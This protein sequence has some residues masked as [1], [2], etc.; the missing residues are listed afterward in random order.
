[1]LRRRKDKQPP[2][3]KA[4]AVAWREFDREQEREAFRGLGPGFGRIPSFGRRRSKS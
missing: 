4:R 3:E 1:M 2:D